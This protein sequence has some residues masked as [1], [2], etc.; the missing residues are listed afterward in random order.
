MPLIIADGVIK[1]LN[2][3]SPSNPDAVANLVSPELPLVAQIHQPELTL[4]IAADLDAKP[5]GNALLPRRPETNGPVN[6][7]A[8]PMHAV[9]YAG[10]IMVAESGHRE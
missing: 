3:R 2:Y 1:P 8:K 4:H 9:P 6:A 5:V 10:R 7:V